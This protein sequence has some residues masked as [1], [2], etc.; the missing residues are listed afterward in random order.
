[1]AITEQDLRAYVSKEMRL[2]TNSLQ[3]MM[4]DLKW[5]RYQAKYGGKDYARAIWVKEPYALD[6]GQIIGP[7]GSKHAVCD[8]LWASEQ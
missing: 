8:V 3:Y 4:S 6:R 5:N 1:M 2:S 7:D